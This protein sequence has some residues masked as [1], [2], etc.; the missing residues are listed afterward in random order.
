MGIFYDPILAGGPCNPTFW[1]EGEGK[2]MPYL[3]NSRNIH[4]IDLKLGKK[5]YTNKNF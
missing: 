3:F 4:A 1:L 2:E 5:V